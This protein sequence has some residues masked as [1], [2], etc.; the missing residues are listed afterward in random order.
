ML[1]SAEI[2]R[3]FIALCVVEIC[4]IG[5]SLTYKPLR[6]IGVPFSMMTQCTT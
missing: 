4:D 1:K 3:H 2:A 6:S 5:Y